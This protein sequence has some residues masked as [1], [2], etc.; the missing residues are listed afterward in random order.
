MRDADVAAAAGV[1]SSISADGAAVDGLTAAVASLGVF[2]GVLF[3]AV[4]AGYCA[5]ARR[6]GRA[7]PPILKS[8]TRARTTP[9]AGSS[10][11]CEASTFSLW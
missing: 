6:R 5:W 10:I 9:G 2:V 4:P 1:T 7:P 11:G 8:G 3:L